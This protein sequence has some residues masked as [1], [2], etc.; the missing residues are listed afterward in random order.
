MSQY[1]NEEEKKAFNAARRGKYEHKKP[2]M[3]PLQL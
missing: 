1:N 2:E 3:K